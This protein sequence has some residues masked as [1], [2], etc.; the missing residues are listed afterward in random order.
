MSS[1]TRLAAVVMSVSMSLMATLPDPIGWWKMDAAENGVVAD[2]SG[3]GRNLTLGADIILSNVVYGITKKV[4]TLYF[5]GTTDSYASFSCP[6]LTDRTFSIWFWRESADGPLAP[7]PNSIPYY[8]T[9]ISSMNMS[10]RRMDNADPTV[11]EPFF[12][13]FSGDKTLFP[14]GG[15]YPKT[16]CYAS[17]RALHNITITVSTTGRNNDNTYNGSVMVYLD[18]VL[19]GQKTGIFPST[20]AYSQTACIGNNGVRSNRPLLGHIGECRLYDTALTTAQ[21]AELYLENLSG[22]LLAH[23]DMENIIDD[24][25][26]RR[27]VAGTGGGPVLSVGSAMTVTNW[28]AALR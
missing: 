6:A 24:G 3:N 27:Y 4:P 28:I 20:L 15:Y 17:R 10:A 8:F 12:T 9:A 16:Y 5:Q 19:S 11:G 26:G 1:K 14:D 18:G 22:A 21:V 2:L 13:D 7:E 25:A 23:W